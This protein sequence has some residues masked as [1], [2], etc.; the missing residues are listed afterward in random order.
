M[1]K[2][3]LIFLMN[4]SFFLGF[5]QFDD[6]DNYVKEFI[7]GLTT[8]TNSSLIG[9][10]VFRYGRSHKEDIFE[11]F[12]IELVNVAHPSE[13]KYTSSQNGSTFIWGKQNRLL[14]IRGQYGRDK[15]IYGKESPKGVQINANI[16]IG[17]TIGI[18][19]PYY[20]LTSGGEYVIYDPR[21]YTN[22]QSIQGSGKF[23]QGLGEAKIIPGINT[24]AALN[25]EFG[26]FMRNAIGI[27]FGLMAEGY[28]KQIVIVPTKTNKAF[29]TSAFFT[30]FWGKRIY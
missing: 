15:I 3:I 25:F 17:P 9:G 26:S 18:V 12:G 19:I 27:E 14:A 4:L 22:L 20:V 5:A 23:L 11:T 28:V 30:F 24:K 2:V 16:A 6:T 29:Y 21:K 7:W 10:A 13:Q 8:N 1:L